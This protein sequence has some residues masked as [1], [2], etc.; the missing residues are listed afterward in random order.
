MM[1]QAPGKSQS[2]REPQSTPQYDFLRPGTKGTPGLKKSNRNLRVADSLFRS[3][4]AIAGYWLDYFL[5]PEPLEYP[6]AQ[7]CLETVA[8]KCDTDAI[9]DGA[10][11]P[12]EFCWL[13]VW[14]FYFIN[15]VKPVQNALKCGCRSPEGESDKNGFDAKSSGSCI[16]Q[17]G[18]RDRSGPANHLS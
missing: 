11:S 15:P 7:D 10:V 5:D 13:S 6:I 17:G 1:Y 8:R 2:Q 4:K 9:L 14:E 18:A 16:A 12:R 3:S